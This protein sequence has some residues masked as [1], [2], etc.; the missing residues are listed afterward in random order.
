M[1]FA[2]FDFIVQQFFINSR[3]L[4]ITKIN[5]GLIHKTYIIEHLFNGEKSKF[6]LQRLSNIFES[7]EKVSMN[8]NLITDHI[9]KRISNSSILSKLW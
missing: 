9:K 4:N 3:V 2:K 1:E 6:I 5:S 8:H 7:H